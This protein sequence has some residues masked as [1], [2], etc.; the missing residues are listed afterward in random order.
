[1]LDALVPSKATDQALVL[2]AKCLDDYTATAHYTSRA[3]TKRPAYNPFKL[4]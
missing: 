3:Y 1:M 4:D 2:C